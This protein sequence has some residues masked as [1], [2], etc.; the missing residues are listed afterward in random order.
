MKLA[1]IFGVIFVVAAMAMGIPAESEE[2]R[3]GETQLHDLD[4]I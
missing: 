3:P 2:T 4:I 1:C